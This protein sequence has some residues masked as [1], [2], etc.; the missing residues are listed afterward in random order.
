MN[1]AVMMETQNQQVLQTPLD[2]ELVTL[3]IMVQN[4]PLS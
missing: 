1:L 3:I 4:Q 2:L